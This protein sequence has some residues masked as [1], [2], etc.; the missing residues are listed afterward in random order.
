MNEVATCGLIGITAREMAAKLE[1]G[2]VTDVAG[3][4]G[5]GLSRLL[6]EMGHQD[7][8]LIMA[9]TNDLGMGTSPEAIFASIRQLHEACHA[10]GIPT[11]A[12]APP[13]GLGGPS[14]FAK[15]RLAEML[16]TWA[17][18][19]SNV[20]A[21][22]DA[23]EILPR[24]DRQAWE[25]DEFHFSAAGCLLFGQRLAQRIVD[26]S[27]EPGPVEARGGGSP[28][29]LRGRSPR[30]ILRSLSNRF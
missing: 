17:S 22:Y 1:N 4:V 3:A 14:R 7:L 16:A 11:I 23:E 8:A 2:R 6:T 29:F 27:R 15:Q 24:S 19:T 12:F 9:G 25:P 28:R 20:V 13:T 10:R 5:K 26:S 21:Y 30:N 18:T